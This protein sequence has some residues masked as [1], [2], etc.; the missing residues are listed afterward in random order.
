M[1]RLLLLVLST[2][3]SEGKFISGRMFDKGFKLSS[4]CN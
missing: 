3:K 2:D 1:P 4:A